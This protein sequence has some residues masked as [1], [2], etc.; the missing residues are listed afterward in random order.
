MI[1]TV[2]P[3]QFQD[4]LNLWANK[5]TRADVREELKSN[6]IHIA[7]FRHYLELEPA[8]D[9]DIL[10][11]IGFDLPIIPMRH[12]RVTHFWDRN[13]AWL[14]GLVGNDGQTVKVEFWETALDHYALYGI[15]DLEKGETYAAPQFVQRFGNFTKFLPEYGGPSRLRSH[16]EEVKQHL[17]V[18]N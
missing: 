6:D 14:R 1:R 3:A 17:Y 7:A 13:D 10:G 5:E 4:L 18:A 16:L 11:K 8:D 12:D 9:V 15:D 2:A